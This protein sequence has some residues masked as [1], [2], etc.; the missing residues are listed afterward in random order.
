MWTPSQSVTPHTERGTQM[1]PYENLLMTHNLTWT[2]VCWLGATWYRY[3]WLFPLFWTLQL[4]VAGKFIRDFL[5]VGGKYLWVKYN[6]TERWFKNLAQIEFKSTHLY[7]SSFGMNL[8]CF[9]FW[10]KWHKNNNLGLDFIFVLF[11]HLN[12]YFIAE[13]YSLCCAK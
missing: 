13:T 8:I 2:S 1:L 6:Q 7:N 5:L 10:Q 9:P 12:M 11:L 4:S 3:R